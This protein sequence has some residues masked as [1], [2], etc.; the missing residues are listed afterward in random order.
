MLTSVSHGCLYLPPSHIHPLSNWEDPPPP[1][2][3]NLL[4]Y[5]WTIFKP[6]DQNK[7]NCFWQTP[8]SAKLTF[9][10]FIWICLRKKLLA[11]FGWKL[12]AMKYFFM[13]KLGYRFYYIQ[14]ILKYIDFVCVPFWRELIIL[15][16]FKK[17]S[18]ILV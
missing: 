9:G 4:K 11:F 1:P 7:L 8:T 17:H 14:M 2:I 16:N 3:K 5:Y 12:Y 13:K 10:E 18:W 6:A 15:S